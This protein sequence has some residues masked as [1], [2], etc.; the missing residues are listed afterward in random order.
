[1]AKTF[2][3]ITLGCKVN[4]FESACLRATLLQAGWLEAP[5]GGKADASIINTCIVTRRASYQS[6]QAVRRAIRENPGG[7]TA[8]VGCYAVVFPDHFMDIRGLDLV[9]GNRAKFRLPDLLQVLEKKDFPH[10]VPEDLSSPAFPD[11]LPVS[12][13]TRAVLKIQDGCDSFCSYCIVPYARGPV[14]SLDPLRVLE[15]LE[16]LSDK[17]YREVVLTGIH[18]GRYGSDLQPPP[19]LKDLLVLIGRKKLGLRVRLSSL[20]P[21]E[22]GHELIEMVASEAWLCRHFHIPLQ[23]GDNHILEKMNRHYTAKEFRSLVEEIHVRVPLAA[24]GVDIL[25]GFPGEG[26]SAHLSTCNLVQDLPLSYFHVFPYS[27]REG[28]S[29]WSLPGRVPDRDIRRRTAG[30]RVLGEEKRRSFYESCVGKTF[31]VLSE[32]W[33]KEGFSIKGLS[34]NYVPVVFESSKASQNEMVSVRV[35]RV[36]AKTVYGTRCTGPLVGISRG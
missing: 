19:S 31:E 25:S 15:N 33:E 3:V 2:R 6:R 27:P 35:D 13:R 11:L 21:K 10:L 1:V 16:A 34:D 28:T 36:D 14:R 26:E 22:I 24:I 12:G 8:A 17:G 32:G 20:E 9:A 4:Q 5:R 29:A 23:S 18:L 30:L 7:L